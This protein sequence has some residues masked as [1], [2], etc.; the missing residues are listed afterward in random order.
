MSIDSKTLAGGAA[1]FMFLGSVIGA[2]FAACIP[3]ADPRLA[4]AEKDF[5]GMVA[6]ARAL[7]AITQTFPAPGTPRA[8]LEADQDRFCVVLSTA[9][10]DGGA[11]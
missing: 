8:L 11:K 3:A 9:T 7:E 4:A 1:V 2:G 10:R 5:C 6:G